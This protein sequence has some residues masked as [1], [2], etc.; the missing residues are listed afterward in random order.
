MHFYDH[1]A[2]HWEGER[3]KIMDSIRRRDFSFGELALRLFDLQ[4]SFNPIY[5]EYVNL[6]YGA[7]PPVNHPAEIPFLPI[8]FFKSHRIQTGTFNPQILF[9]SSG[10]TV[11]VKSLH[12]V[13][14]PAWYH[15]ISKTCFNESFFPLGVSDF[16]H[17]AI[18]PS[19]MENKASSLLHMVDYFIREGA[20]GYFHLNPSGLKEYIGKEGIG[21]VAIWGVSFALNQWPGILH[22]P[23]SCWIIE[24]GGM[25]GR[26]VEIT[27]Q[28]LHQNIRA[29]F[30]GAQVAS[31][32]GMTELLSQAY[33][34]RDGVFEPRFTLKAFPRQINDPLS[35]ESANQQAV[36]NFIDLANIDSCAFIAT[37]DL[38]RVY[39][40]GRFEVLGRLDYSEVRGCNLLMG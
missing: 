9:E 18:L 1:C 5:R 2:M 32:Y 31:E 33:A 28:E 8:Q 20:G 23:P 36:L 22:C 34:L 39:P 6:V 37:E 17:L 12:P 30:I 29:R 3:L 13:R 7:K 40:D 25:K 27:R 21:Q 11:Q 35:I 15:F 10:T 26:S 16:S 14:D 38:G 19:Y 4:Y 24:T